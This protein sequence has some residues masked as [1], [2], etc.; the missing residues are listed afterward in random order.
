MR[1]LIVNADDLGLTRGI[2]KGIAQGFRLGIITSA[3]ALVNMP[4]WIHAAGMAKKLPGLGIGLHFNLTLGSPLTDPQA[5]PTL[6]NKQGRFIGDSEQLARADSLEVARELYNQYHRLLRSGIRPTHIDSHED[7]HA[8]DNILVVLLAFATR[9]NLPLRLVPQ[10]KMRY[11][12]AGVATTEEIILEFQDKAANRFN[13]EGLISRCQGTTVELRCH[14]G[15][16]DAELEELS[17]Y[18]W[19]RER[20]LAVLCAYDK[21]GFPEGRGFELISFAGLRNQASKKQTQ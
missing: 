8:L 7:I 21:E 14:P 3:T 11:S 20:E 4:C 17:T 15:M 13:F 9:H 2:N 1:K 5:I 12:Y 10:E 19:Q 16:V 6:V 18:T